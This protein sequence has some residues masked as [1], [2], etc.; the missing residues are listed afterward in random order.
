MTANPALVTVWCDQLKNFRRP[1]NVLRPFFAGFYASPVAGPA[2]GRLCVGAA[3][4]FCRHDKS[5][6]WGILKGHS[7]FNSALPTFSLGRKWVASGRNPA[8]HPS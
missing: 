6:A 3:G 4:D 1:N 8:E 5:T 2:A 7:P